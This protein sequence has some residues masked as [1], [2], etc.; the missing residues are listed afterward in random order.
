VPKTP[1]FSDIE[2][3]R[4]RDYDEVLTDSL[5]LFDSRDKTGG[6]QLDYHGN[7]IPQIATQILTRYTRR[8]DVVVDLFLGSGTS[9]IEAARMGRRCVGVELKA[10]LAEYVRS[11]FQSGLLFSSGVGQEAQICVL[12]GDSSAPQVLKDVQDVLTA[13]GRTHAQLVILHPPYHDIICFS[14]SLEDLCNAPDT[15]SFLDRFLA[16]A[17]NAIAL[18]EPG[19]FACLVIGDKYA[20]GELVPLG[21]YCMQRMNEAGF[22]TKAIVVKDI[23]RNERGKGRSANLWRY[24]ALSGGYYIFKHEYV[25]IFQ[26]PG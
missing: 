26:K 19:R 25:M 5:W 23:Q 21:F 15:G 20:R 6:H 9:A 11:K 17:S 4:W 10:E 14:D 3:E 1:P 18:L 8:D 22:R 7:F 16:V 2:L 12:Q 24:R 13:W